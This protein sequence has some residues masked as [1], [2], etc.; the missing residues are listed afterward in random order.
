MEGVG[1]AE[2]GRDFYLPGK[3]PRTCENRKRQPLQSTVV[4]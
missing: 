4:K 2:Q 3:S 1:G